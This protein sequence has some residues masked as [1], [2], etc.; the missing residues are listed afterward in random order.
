MSDR[1][2]T[3]RDVPYIRRTMQDDQNRRRSQRI[4]VRATPED[5]ALIDRAVA[6]ADTSV[7]AFVLSSVTTAAR[8]VLTDRTEFVLSP[9]AAAAWEAINA[10]PA[11]DLPGLRE[12]MQ[13]P[14]PF[15]TE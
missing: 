12:L 15:V 3:D 8:Q 6:A 10:R 5:R 1:L 9:E 14:S 2:P 7:T 4:E 13:R 11:R